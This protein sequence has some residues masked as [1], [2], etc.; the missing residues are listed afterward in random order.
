MRRLTEHGNATILLFASSALL[1]QNSPPSNGPQNPS[2][3]PD[4][5][6]IVLSSV[7]ATQ[8]QWRTWV[9]YNYLERD[10][11]RHMDLAGRVKSE[12]VDVSRALLVNGVQFEQLVERNGRPPSAEEERKQNEEIEKLKRLTPEQRTE[13]LR[14]E[15]EEN[16]SLV[17]EVPKAFDFK[18]AGEEVVNGRPGYLKRRPTPATRRGPSTARCSPKLRVSFG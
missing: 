1:A 5:R 18:P 3:A 14:K 13:Q 2:S 12:E 8:R 7:A 15:E 11:T 6:Q 17:A 9:L 4:V 16:T 10:E